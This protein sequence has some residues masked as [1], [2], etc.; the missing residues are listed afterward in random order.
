[1]KR[2]EGAVQYG[3]DY[4]SSDRFRQ[5]QTD[6]FIFAFFVNSFIHSRNITT[7]KRR[8]NEGQTKD[9]CGHTKDI[10]RTYEGLTGDKKFI[11][12]RISR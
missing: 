1:M 2:G 9:T 8:T 4:L 12:S 6:S 10:R 7:D 5:I 11:H 3:S